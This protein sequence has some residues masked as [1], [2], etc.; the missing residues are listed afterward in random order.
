M[1]TQF[2]ESHTWENQHTGLSTGT[3]CSAGCEPGKPA[4]NPYAIRHCG[5]HRWRLFQKEG[6]LLL[7]T[8]TASWSWQGRKQLWST[9]EM[10]TGL[11]SVHQ[12]LSTTSLRQTSAKQRHSL[13]LEYD[14]MTFDSV[15]LRPANNSLVFCNHSNLIYIRRSLLYHIYMM[16]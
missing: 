2:P 14:Y 16:W 5:C 9:R 3:H 4:P 7:S 8:H 6:F 1:L 15:P 13:L 10:K 12:T 11:F